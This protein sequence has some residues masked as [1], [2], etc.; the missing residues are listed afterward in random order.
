M[1]VDRPSLSGRRGT[2]ALPIERHR[3][4]PSRH[5]SSSPLLAASYLI[6]HQ[7][8]LVS[9]L[10][11]IPDGSGGPVQEKAVGRRCSSDLRFIAEEAEVP[12]NAS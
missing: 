11:P 10:Q 9:L 3:L 5:P 6:P 4:R 7:V 12:C 8:A 2:F 1:D